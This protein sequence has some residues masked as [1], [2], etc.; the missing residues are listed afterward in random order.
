MSHA[1]I[2]REGVIFQVEQRWEG[3]PI[4][5]LPPEANKAIIT[6]CGAW[7]AG[8]LGAL[9]TE[10][11]TITDAERL[12]IAPSEV[13]GLCLNIGSKFAVQ[14]GLPD[15]L[16]EKVDYLRKQLEDDPSLLESG[17]TLNLVSIDRPSYKE[18][19]DRIK[20]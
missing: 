6:F 10:L 8:E 2:S 12:E 14:L 11:V 18:G 15:K 4:L 16:D 17:R 13:G 9:C 1:F 3:L 20:K 7:R 5:H 19:V